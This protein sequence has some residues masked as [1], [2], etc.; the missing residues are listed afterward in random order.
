[1]YNVTTAQKNKRRSLAVR[2][3]LEQETAWVWG[4]ELS[5]PWGPLSHIWSPPCFCLFHYRELS[6]T[7]SGLIIITRSGFIRDAAMHRYQLLHTSLLSLFWLCFCLCPF[8]YTHA[9]VHAYKHAYQ[10][11]VCP[12]GSY[13][14]TQT[15][16][17]QVSHL[18]FI[19][20]VS[21]LH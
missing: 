5:I 21:R 8:I 13:I 2:T 11:Q 17:K 19:S 1:M 3:Y 16:D 9:Y 18:P 4:F 14:L 12:F 20:L 7:W 6:S 15:K 10:H